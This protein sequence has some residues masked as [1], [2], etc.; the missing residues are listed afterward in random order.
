MVR[1]ILVAKREYVDE[2]TKD[3]IMF[4]T[5]YELGKK[6]K[7][8]DVIFNKRST[9]AII[10]GMI[11]KTKKPQDYLDFLDIHPG[12]LIDIEYAVGDN[13][14]AYIKSYSLVHGTNLYK[15]EDLYL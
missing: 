4:L 15:P 5:L 3:N 10:N 9:D 2:K 1:A 6:I 14:K 12:A 13:R 11:N 7:D 8:S